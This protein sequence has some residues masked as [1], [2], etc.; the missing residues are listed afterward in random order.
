MPSSGVND[1]RK[2]GEETQ[3][4]GTEIILNK[5]M[6]EKVSKLKKRMPINV[7]EAYRIS[8][9]LGQKRNSLWHIIIKTFHIQNKK[10]L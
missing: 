3:V 4:K 2:E 9:R 10:R 5:I 8:N 7:Q 6:E 1:G